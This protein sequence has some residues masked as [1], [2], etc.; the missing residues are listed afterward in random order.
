MLPIEK[1]AYITQYNPY[2]IDPKYSKKINFDIFD[3]FDLN[4]INNEFIENYRKMNFEI[5][6]KEKIFEYIIKIID[7]IKT[8]PDIDIIIKLVNI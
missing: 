7:K 6:F 2:Y 3:L 5:I 1:L 8:I 4:N